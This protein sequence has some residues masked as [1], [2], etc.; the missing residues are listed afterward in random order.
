M[1]KTN[2]ATIVFALTAACGTTKTEGREDNTT[3]AGIVTTNTDSN[4]NPNKGDANNSRLDS[5]YDINTP[6]DAG[7]DANNIQDMDARFVTE[8]SGM[9][10]ANNEIRDAGTTQ[11]NH[12]PTLEIPMARLTATNGREMTLAVY[13]NDSDN[14]SLEYKFEFNDDRTA[15]DWD[16]NNR[17]THTF[18]TNGEYLVNANV[19]DNHGGQA[20]GTIDVT[21]QTA[22]YNNP[23]VVRLNCNERTEDGRCVFRFNTHEQI[24]WDF[25]ETFDPDG[26]SINELRIYVNSD[27]QNSFDFLRNRTLT[28]LDV[29]GGYGTSGTFNGRAEAIDSR[30]ITGNLGF[31]NIINP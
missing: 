6:K 28:H 20:S 4:Y 8:D 29:C 30:S 16:V 19:R 18:R 26:D 17:T 2:L 31:L 3:D 12:A 21:V 15:R 27:S 11:G 1:R 13:G 14:D 7:R 5:Q 22:D 25:N 23:P 10:D 9:R 24:C